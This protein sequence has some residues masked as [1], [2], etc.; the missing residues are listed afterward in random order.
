MYS[1]LCTYKY[2]YIYIHTYSDS[3][4]RHPIRNHHKPTINGRKKHGKN[5]APKSPN[6]PFSISHS[7]SPWPK[8]IRLTPGVLVAQL[9]AEVTT[10]TGQ[11]TQTGDLQ[12]LGLV[13]GA[14][15]IWKNMKV[16][17][18]WITFHFRDT[19]HGALGLA[20]L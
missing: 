3:E 8:K 12:L 1:Y 7:S 20:T 18:W 6:Q 11:G 19:V 10:A 5:E 17:G 13:G 2:I 15:T 16:N 4:W 14:I 9:R